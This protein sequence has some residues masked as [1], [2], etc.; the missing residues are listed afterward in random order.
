MSLKDPARIKNNYVLGVDVG[1]ASTKMVLLDTGLNIVST[2][3]LPTSGNPLRA[4]EKALENIESSIVPG[5]NIDKVAVTGSGRELVAPKLEADMVK[6]EITCQTRGTLYSQPGARTI[7]EIGGQGSKMIVVRKGMVVDFGMNTVCAAGTGSFLDHQARRLGIGVEDL[8]RLAMEAL[9]PV[10]INATCTVFAES[11][12]VSKQQ[13]GALQADVIYGLCIALA[14]N[15]IRS[16][17]GSRPVEAPLV[18]QGGVAYNMGMVR[19]LEEKLGI[20]ICI[21]PQPELTGALGAAL[22]VSEKPRG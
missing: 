18:F 6:N 12:M 5:F 19:A 13:S 2:C 1:S 15:F 22:L 8:S 10:A 4:V 11:D 20:Q 14:D 21:P 17:V 7:L 9:H 3:R 16:V